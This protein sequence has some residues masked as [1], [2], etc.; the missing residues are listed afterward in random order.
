MIEQV[1]RSPGRG[2]GYGARGGAAA[3]PED[4]CC[5]PVESF[6][7]KYDWFGRPFGLK[8]DTGKGQVKSFMGTLCTLTWIIIMVVFALQKI[9]TLIGKKSIR[10]LSSVKDLYFKDDNEFDYSL[11]LNIAVA[12][13][14]YDSSTDWNLE[15]KYGELV[16]NSFSWGYKDDGTPFT[17]RKP[18]KM[19][20]CTREEL[21]LDAKDGYNAR[22]FPLHQS[23]K[24]NVDLWWKKF[25]C[26]DEED[27][28]ISG[29]YNS[30]AAR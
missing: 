30:E 12:F 25:L 8:M 17:E 14:P 22:F 29:D 28:R 5:Q 23:T 3:P 7:K 13:T 15:A 11:G 21:N 9:D 4:D 26:I 16:I 27:L 1:S 2:N 18:V 24:A 6:L 10:I 20:N 19:H